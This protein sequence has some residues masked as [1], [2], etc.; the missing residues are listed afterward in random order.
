MKKLQKVFFVLLVALAAVCTI[1][2]CACEKPQP[3]NATD[4]EV[5]GAPTGEYAVGTQF[6]PSALSVVVHFDDGSE[7]KIEYSEN[8]EISFSGWDTSSEGEKSFVVKCMGLEK[9]FAY[10]VRNNT[11][12]LVLNGGSLVLEGETVENSYNFV[13]QSN[14]V[15]LGDYYPE[16]TENG[17]AMAFAGWY[18]DEECTQRAPLVSD[19]FAL[20]GDVTLYAG[21]DTDWSWLFDYTISVN[22]ETNQMEVTLNCFTDLFFIWD[23][24]YMAMGNVLTIP[25]TVEGY[26][27]TVLGTKFSKISLTDYS[28]FEMLDFDTITFHEDSPLR[29]IGSEAFANENSHSIT[30]FDFPKNLKVIGEKAFYNSMIE[31]EKV[32][33]PASLEKIL[34]DAFYAV[35]FD[36]I[37]FEA[38]SN[39][40]SIGNNAF[41]GCKATKI[42]LPEGLSEIGKYAFSGSPYIT[43]MRI[44]ASVTSIGL[45]AFNSMNALER[46]E[47]S[48]DNAVYWSGQGGN[49][50]QYGESAGE[51]YL[52]RYCN[53]DRTTEFS[54]PTK[55]NN[56]NDVTITRI[57]EAAFS[58]KD[59]SVSGNNNGYSY[60]EKINLT[61]GLKYIGDKAFAGISAQFTLPASLANIGAMAFYDWNG[62]EFK[63]AEG[64][65]DFCVEE[66]V[67]YSADGKQILSVPKFYPTEKGVFTLKNDVEVVK[68]YAFVKNETIEYLVFPE[69]SNLKKVESNGLCIYSMPSLKGVYLLGD[70]FEVQNNAFYDSSFLNQA[71][72]IFADDPNAYKNNES[73]KNY[74]EKNDFGIFVPLIDRIFAFDAQVLADYIGGES[75]NFVSF[76][77]FD[78]TQEFSPDPEIY[79]DIYN[80][81]YALEKLNALFNS[82]QGE[83]AVTEKYMQYFAA[84]EKFAYTSIVEYFQLTEEFGMLQNTSVQEIAIVNSVVVGYENVLPQE[85]K[86]ELQESYAYLA[87]K[88]EYFDDL[89]AK[90]NQAIKDV[91]NFQLSEENLDDENSQYSFDRLQQ[92]LTEC[93]NCGVVSGQTNDSFNEKMTTLTITQTLF[94]LMNTECNDL[95]IGYIDTVQY[96][97]MY[98][99]EYRMNLLYKYDK[100]N[101]AICNALI[102]EAT[103]LYDSFG[104]VCG[105]NA[106]ELRQ[107]IFDGNYFNFVYYHFFEHSVEYYLNNVL[108]ETEKAQLQGLEKYNAIKAE[109]SEIFDDI[110][111]KVQDFQLS[112]ENLMD[113]NSQYSAEKLAELVNRWY[114]WNMASSVQDQQVLDAFYLLDCNLALY[115]LHT[116]TFNDENAY[117]LLIWATNAD[118]YTT[119][120]LSTEQMEQLV[121]LD[122]FET[123]KDVVYCNFLLKALKESYEWYGVSQANAYELSQ[124]LYDGYYTD[125]YVYITLVNPLSYYMENVFTTE[126]SRLALVNFDI[127]QTV[128]DAY[129]SFVG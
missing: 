28:A 79:Y 5:F 102:F 94:L 95:T 103:S 99:S 51:S 92:L 110:V 53:A 20:T 83:N 61:E 55:D 14:V 46:I 39:L 100:M 23:E 62:T 50:Y 122:E 64:N 16:K 77:N 2:L 109:Y 69:N 21:Y 108:T 105:Y 101:W 84:F 12:T 24:R 34:N 93:A 22:A 4:M 107:I 118:Y 87:E 86:T 3:A 114:D 13:A 91:M 11:V 59:L 121:F 90:R 117:D 78:P 125:Y 9:V 47:V 52:V 37:S 112:E 88:K 104:G 15:D 25:N 81:S 66:G 7:K 97:A 30:T 17:Y 35:K 98:Q 126:E 48:A 129:D 36:E 73:W 65:K 10:S 54:L 1:A 43:Y 111:Q 80:I 33:F 75:I 82:K 63:L 119:Y 127:Y 128:K 32:V 58:V 8:G 71:L 40:K 19:T 116:N 70:V 76:D 113:E 45:Y 26:P 41:E 72:I 120:M 124:L 74:T 44:P 38:G 115:S 31:G 85:I 60:L 49:L 89:T 106:S 42:T 27:V 18:L 68:S 29:E 6:D 57:L 96:H 56:G 123:T 67:L